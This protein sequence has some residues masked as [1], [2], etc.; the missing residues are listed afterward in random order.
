MGKGG[1]GKRVELMKRKTLFTF[2]LFFLSA[3]IRVFSQSATAE[4]AF[5]SGVAFYGQSKWLDALTQFRLA[6]EKA[7]TDDDKAEAQ[8][9]ICL[10]EQSAANH[11]TVL[12]E[13]DLLT[14]MKGRADRKAEIPY[15]KGRSF[16]YLE[17]YDEAIPLLKAYADH[18]PADSTENISRKSAGLYWVGE[19]LFALGQ[20]D[21]A[22][23]VFFTIVRDYPQSV[24]YEAASYRISLV[25]QKRIE[26]ELLDLLKWTHEES[27]KTIEEY[28]RRERA[29]NQALIAYQK[30]IAALEESLRE[31]RSDAGK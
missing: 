31:A 7:E 15:I 26:K 23:D 16:Y 11:S 30:R 18:I 17:R 25:N 19:C 21:R 14:Q 24:K 28:Q 12:Q 13:L 29:Y 2:F 10:A 6:R 20:L 5:Q 1:G 4:T 8:Y 9:W 27:L 22:E 3:D